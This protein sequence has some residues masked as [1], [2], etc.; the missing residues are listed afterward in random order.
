MLVWQSGLRT[1]CGGWGQMNMG[2]GAV[3]P[4]LA[5]LAG[6]ALLMVVVASAQDTRTVTEPKIP[7]SC[8]Q[9]PAQLRA[10]NDK[11]AE[12]DERK[13]DTARIQA[14]LDKCTPGM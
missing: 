11:V 12:A 6:M 1:D 7:A 2:R 10:M 4:K 8:V 14:A 9:L 13:L 3:Y 5:A